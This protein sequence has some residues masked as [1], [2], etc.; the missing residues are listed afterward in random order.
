MY[1]QPFYITQKVSNNAFNCEKRPHKKLYV[2][3]LV[4]GTVDDVRLGAE[5]VFEDFNDEQNLHTCTGLEKFIKTTLGHAPAYIF[6]NHNHAFAFWCLEKQN[7]RL[8]DNALLIHIDQ[9][10]DTRV[11]EKFLSKE[12][13]A[14]PKK[15]FEYTNTFL[16]VGNFIPAAQHIGLV[17]EII[18]LDSE[19]SLKEMEE[20]LREDERLL[21]GA[22]PL[23]G[24]DT[25]LAPAR[26]PLPS[27]NLILDIDLDFFA[28]ESDYIGNDLKLAVIQKLL[29]KASIITFATSPYFIDQTRALKW[30]RR[31]A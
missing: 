11:P 23:S 31:I 28:P 22:T 5:I 15:V 8:Q 6:D 14:D 18:F 19:Y 26:V 20:R 29:P 4:E 16:N 12:N 27:E 17:K 3:Q 24:S 21:S 9:H 25:R 1:D 7:G 13:S 2:P 10:K 30:L